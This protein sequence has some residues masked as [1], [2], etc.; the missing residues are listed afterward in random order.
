MKTADIRLINENQGTGRVFFH[1]NDGQTICR[2]MTMGE[3]KK[4]QLIRKN[5]GV[6][7]FKEYF[8]NLFNEK[9]SAPQNTSHKQSALEERIN[10]L[11]HYRSLG[12]LD[13]DGED[14]L[15]HLTDLAQF[16][17]GEAEYIREK[18]ENRGGAREGA[19]RPRS[20]DE[21]TVVL[22]IRCDE[23]TA[24]RLRQAAANEGLS[25]GKMVERLLDEYAK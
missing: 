17:T 9:Y 23:R 25:L 7:A 22:G 14:E 1:T 16:S 13:S 2:I 18:V 11:R 24:N 21:R 8:V 4:G 15:R 19:G 10:E 6:E 20:F 3:V 5:E 12:I